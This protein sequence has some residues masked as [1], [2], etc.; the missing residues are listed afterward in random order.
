M[1]SSKSCSMDVLPAERGTPRG[2]PASISYSAHRP[3]RIT[4]VVGQQ[5][6]LFPCGEVRSDG[7]RLIEDEVRI[8]RARPAFGRLV[9]LVSERADAGRQWHTARIEEAGFAVAHLPIKARR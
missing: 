9:D 4:H 2:R 5:L 8:G 3:E 1:L 7:V 6:R